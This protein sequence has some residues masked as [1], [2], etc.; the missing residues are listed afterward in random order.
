MAGVNSRWK[1]G[2]IRYTRDSER[3]LTSFKEA[4][5]WHRAAKVIIPRKRND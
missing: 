2:N 5:G 1:K 4:P 3:F